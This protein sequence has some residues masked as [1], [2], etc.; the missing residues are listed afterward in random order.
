MRHNLPAQALALALGLL[1]LL[2]APGS[3][4]A[5]ESAPA[6]APLSTRQVEGLFERWNEALRGNDPAQVA[7]LYSADALLLPTLS[8][9]PRSDQAGIEAY[10][11]GFLAQAPEGQIDSREIRIGCN[12]AL[13]AGTYTFVL[14]PPGEA[15]RHLSARYSFVY[16]Y[17]DGDWR[18]LHHHSSLM[19]AA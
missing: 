15:E 13:D 4:A 6:C 2:L 1:L 12:Q 17:R 7:A 14:H 18:I 8:D 3:S 19:P 16:V 11:K 10:F 9:K 5:L